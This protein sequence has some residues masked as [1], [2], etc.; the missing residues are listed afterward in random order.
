VRVR[1]Q[2]VPAARDRTWAHL[3]L[4]SRA[5]FP[6]R[7]WSQGHEALAVL[8]AAARRGRMRSSPP[9]AVAPPAL[10]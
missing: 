8:D 7:Y 5:R 1:L 6:R 2:I 9:L 3:V 4:D 10:P